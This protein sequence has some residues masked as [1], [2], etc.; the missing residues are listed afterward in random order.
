MEKDFMDELWMWTEVASYHLALL[1]VTNVKH[2]GRAAHPDVGMMK[3]RRRRRPPR[4]IIFSQF[5][6]SAKQ[7]ATNVQRKVNVKR[8]RAP[9]IL[10]SPNSIILPS[11]DKRLRREQLPCSASLPYFRLWEAKNL[12]YTSFGFTMQEYLF[13]FLLTFFLLVSVLCNI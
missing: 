3:L 9:C 5:K 8:F 6:F 2:E 7:N 11:V 4:G 1:K 13:D 10:N 12:Q